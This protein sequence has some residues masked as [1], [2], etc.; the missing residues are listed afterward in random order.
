[1]AEGN[2]LPAMVTVPVTPSP[3]LIVTLLFTVN[4]LTVTFALELISPVIKLPLVKDVAAVTV[5]LDTS[6]LTVAI[7]VAL[8][9]LTTAVLPPPVPKEPF[10]APLNP[11]VAVKEVPV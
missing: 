3:E 2:M 10:K 4:A 6:E 5:E 8:N 1:M 11:L 9:E 7:P